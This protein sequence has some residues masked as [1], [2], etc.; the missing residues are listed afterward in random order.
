[1]KVTRGNISL[2]EGRIVRPAAEKGQQLG[3]EKYVVR[4]GAPSIYGDPTRYTEDDK[5]AAL[6]AESSCVGEMDETQGG[7]Y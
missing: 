3:Q 5:R 2:G 4:E 7:K 6:K 1:M